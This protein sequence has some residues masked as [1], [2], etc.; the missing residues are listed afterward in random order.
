MSP[1]MLIVQMNFSSTIYCDLSSKIIFFMLKYF[2]IH[3]FSLVLSYKGFMSIYM[4]IYFGKASSN[5]P[6]H[7]FLY[8]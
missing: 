5:A 2:K 8:L 3:N 7:A 1:L 4:E 6:I